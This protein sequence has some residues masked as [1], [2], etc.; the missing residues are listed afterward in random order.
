MLYGRLPE[1]SPVSSLCP[2]SC[3]FRMPSCFYGSCGYP[4]FASRT[5]CMPQTQITLLLNYAVF[6]KLKK[7]C[8][9][10]V[11]QCMRCPRV[12]QI[13][14]PVGATVRLAPVY[15]TSKVTLQD[16]HRI[17]DSFKSKHGLHE[18]LSFTLPHTMTG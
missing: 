8:V 6:L 18:L 1:H 17:I 16:R 5:V 10:N 9:L 13:K 15:G 2:S 3:P 14:L 12:L 11:Q 7:K 4:S